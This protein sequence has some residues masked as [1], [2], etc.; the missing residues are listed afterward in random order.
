MSALSIIKKNICIYK[1][2]YEEKCRRN[3]VVR[4]CL[5]TIATAVTA[6]TLT[7]KRTC[8]KLCKLSGIWHNGIAYLF[9]YIV[10][11]TSHRWRESAR[12]LHTCQFFFSCSFA[13]V[14]WLVGWLADWLAR[15]CVCV[16]VA[17]TPNMQT[18]ERVCFFFAARDLFQSLLL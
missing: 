2:S 4:V 9:V 6:A 16:F 1:K 18:I 11:A 10:T 3:G 7:V 5:W 13:C 8:T 15:V 14:N 17:F 12:D